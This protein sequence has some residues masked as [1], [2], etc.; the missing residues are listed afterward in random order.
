MLCAKLLLLAN[1][2]LKVHSSGPETLNLLLPIER[3]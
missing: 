2:I 3:A 1:R